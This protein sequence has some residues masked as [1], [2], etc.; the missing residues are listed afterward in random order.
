MICAI[1]TH[2]RLASIRDYVADPDR[3]ATMAAIIADV[4]ARN[5]LTVDELLK[6]GPAR[7]YAWPRQ[8][9]MRR[10]RAVRRANGEARWSYPQIAARF[11]CDHTTVMHG[12]RQA[13]ARR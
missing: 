5:S 3:R 12:E 11:G 10:C 7:R 9:A 13:E 6:G 8:E 1:V 2:A 4:A